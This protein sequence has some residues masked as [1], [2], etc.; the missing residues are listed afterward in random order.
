[1]SVMGFGYFD[2]GA[3]EKLF[4]VSGLKFKGCQWIKG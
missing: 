2:M 4:K 1:M 3:N